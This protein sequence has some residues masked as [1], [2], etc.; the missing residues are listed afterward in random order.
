MFRP[1]GWLALP[2]F[3]FSVAVGGCLDGFRRFRRF[4]RGRPFIWIFLFLAT[5]WLPRLVYGFLRKIAE[6]HFVKSGVFGE[7]RI[8]G[9]L[10]FAG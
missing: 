3:G 2:G 4:S 7:A 9:N 10:T 6:L 5:R 8:S 1:E